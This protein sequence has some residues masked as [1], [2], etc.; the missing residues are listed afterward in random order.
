MFWNGQFLKACF[1]GYQRRK[2]M[3]KIGPDTYPLYVQKTF[4]LAGCYDCL[5]CCA[6]DAAVL[7]LRSVAACCEIGR[8]QNKSY[9]SQ[10]K[11]FSEYFE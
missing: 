10:S 7:A 5:Q 6:D 9:A 11:Y 8:D 3:L 1:D 2:A 4:M